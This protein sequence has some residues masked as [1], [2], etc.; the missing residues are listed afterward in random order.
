MVLDAL[1]DAARGADELEPENAAD[2]EGVADVPER[3][4][5]GNHE[6]LLL[7][8][9]LVRVHELELRF[10]DGEN[11]WR[12]GGHGSTPGGSGVAEAGPPCGMQF[13]G[14]FVIV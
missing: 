9:L 10:E 8:V 2:L 3:E 12:G 6:P 4:K 7:D 14:G 1:R 13:G 5:I 11:H